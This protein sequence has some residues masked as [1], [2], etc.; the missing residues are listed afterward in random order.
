MLREIG[1]NGVRV[2]ADTIYD[3]TLAATGS[4][5][6]AEDACKQHIAAELRAGRTPL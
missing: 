5:D 1:L 4:R 3:L 6:K 2:S